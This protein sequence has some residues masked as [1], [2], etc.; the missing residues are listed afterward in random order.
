[1]YTVSP[2][3]TIKIGMNLSLHTYKEYQITL[4]N[5]SFT[6]RYCDRNYGKQCRG[7]Q[8]KPWTDEYLPC[9]CT[10]V[11]LEMMDTRWQN[12]VVK[13]VQCLE[14]YTPLRKLILEYVLWDI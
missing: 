14:I 11:V 8:R 1:M 12:E 13:I 2:L 10:H 3:S 5:D 7:I 6:D 9:E 4:V